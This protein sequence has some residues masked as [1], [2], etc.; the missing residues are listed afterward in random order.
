[1]SLVYQ[2]GFVQNPQR[3]RQ[4]QTPT[5]GLIVRPQRNEFDKRET[6]RVSLFIYLS[7]IR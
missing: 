2:A 7:L 1:M 6:L 5:G 3:R 4:P